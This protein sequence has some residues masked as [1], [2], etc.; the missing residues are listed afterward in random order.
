METIYTILDHGLTESFW[1]N[2]GSNGMSYVFIDACIYIYI[3][4]CMSFWCSTQNKLLICFV[5]RGFAYT[6]TIC[7]LTCSL[8]FS[9]NHFASKHRRSRYRSC[10]SSKPLTLYKT[11]CATWSHLCKRLLQMRVLSPH[12]KRAG[13]TDLLLRGSRGGNFCKFERIV[14][15]EN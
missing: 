15:I 9:T 13:E 10:R 14:K 6:L 3:Y 11:P 12:P 8:G 2:F 7:W 4:I 1:R 5:L